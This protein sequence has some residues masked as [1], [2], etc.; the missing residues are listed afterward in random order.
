[1]IR[2]ITKKSNTMK[3]RSSYL[4]I[5]SLTG[6]LAL[7]AKAQFMG[8]FFSQQSQKEKLMAEQIAG[9][10]TFLAALETGYHVAETG[11]NT[12]HE[13][14]NGTF[15]LHSGYF[16]SLEQ[17]SPAIKN[18]PKGRAIDSLY[19][20]IRSLFANEQQWQQQK[21]LLSPAELR[22]LDQVEA[23]LLAKAKLDMDELDEVP[24][25]GKLQLTDAQRLARLDRLYDSMKD[26]LAFAGSFTA[27]CRKLAVARQQQAAEKVK[28][29]SLYG[30]Q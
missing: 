7:P 6:L 15:S 26:K 24:T 5:F 12:A 19:R 29:K 28:L 2:Q 17:V 10:E 16:R 4:L 8:G 18:D 20:Q 30:I 11:L 27:K 9:Y 21:K 23:N 14:K 3:K 25:P 1:M 22:Y 13:L